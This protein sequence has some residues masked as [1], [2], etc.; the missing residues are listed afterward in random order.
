MTGGGDDTTS[1]YS[2][3]YTWDDTTTASGSQTVTAT[4][5]RR[6]DRAP[7]P[8]PSPRTS[9]APTGQTRRRSPAAPGTRAASV[10]LTLDSGSDAG[11]GLD[12]TSG[13]VE[14]A[15]ATLT[16][17]HLRHLR[18]LE[19]RSPSS[20]APTPPSRAATA[21]ATATPSPTTSA[22]P[23]RRP[24]RPPTPRSTPPRRARP[25]PDPDRVLA[26]LLRLRHDPLLQPAGLEHR[27]H[28]MFPSLLP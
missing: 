26:A 28:L 18:R 11:S 1:P 13:V 8:S 5:R 4:Q 10:P 3:S 12:A 23:R 16:E 24:P 19:R 21:T 9:T 22:T 25:S 27:D 14:R 20:A 6:P 15:S 7:P 17:R 2:G